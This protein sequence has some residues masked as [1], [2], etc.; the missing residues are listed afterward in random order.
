[1]SARMRSVR[2]TR[3]LDIRL[4]IGRGVKMEDLMKYCLDNL[5]VSKMTAESYID[6]AA[7]PYRKKYDLEQNKKC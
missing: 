1:M 7:A 5:K 2:H 6:E 4:K 3:I